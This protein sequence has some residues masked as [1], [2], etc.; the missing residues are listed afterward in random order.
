MAG[1]AVSLADVLKT[2]S[3]MCF[4]KGYLRVNVSE[5]A[6]TCMVQAPEGGN[7]ASDCGL[8]AGICLSDWSLSPRVEG[9]PSLAAPAGPPP[10]SCCHV[11]PSPHR[12]VTFYTMQAHQG[13]L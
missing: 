7:R 10:R 2:L 13:L 4:L 8:G 12:S 6:L 5:T 9:G 11:S 1:Q 3:P